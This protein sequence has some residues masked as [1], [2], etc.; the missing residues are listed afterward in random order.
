M[1]SKGMTKEQ[2]RR[3]VSDAKLMNELNN[4]HNDII[5]K[6]MKEDCDVEENFYDMFEE[7]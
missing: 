5:D 6:E 7:E 3:I 2:L 4:N 1:P